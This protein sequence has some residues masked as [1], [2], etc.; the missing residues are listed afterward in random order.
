MAGNAIESSLYVSAS[1]SEL[2][3]AS[4]SLS[5]SF[6]SPIRG[7]TACITYRAFNDPPD[8]MTACPTSLPPI[9]SHSF[10]I[11]PPPFFRI[12]P[13]TPTPNLRYLLAGLTMAAVLS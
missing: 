10:W 12:A 9:V 5:S 13:A 11:I 4:L 8:V 2:R 6:P 3:V 7:P 1:I